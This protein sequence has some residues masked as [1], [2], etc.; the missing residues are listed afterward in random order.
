[1]IK[2][3]QN[4][5]TYYGRFESVVNR[6]SCYSC[7][8]SSWPMIAWWSYLCRWNKRQ[9]RWWHTKAQVMNLSRNPKEKKGMP[10]HSC[11]VV[12][13]VS[14]PPWYRKLPSL[15]ST[16]LTPVPIDRPEL[17]Q[18]RKRTQPHVEGQ[19]A[20]HVY[21]SLFLQRQSPL[22][23]LIDDALTSA[24]KMA[25]TLQDFWNGN[26]SIN[27]ELHISLS[28]PIYLRTHQREDFKKAVKDLST[29]FSP[30]VLVKH[31]SSAQK[32]ICWV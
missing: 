11:C 7:A 32:Q 16:F 4:V 26:L 24:K 6:T 20:A 18:G 13:K 29:R 5:S 12:W 10:Q 23:L 2:R 28:R 27:R 19:W 8:L 30:W 31:I 1:M 21:V 9:M 15:S 17:H 3:R 22:N 14:K 25:P